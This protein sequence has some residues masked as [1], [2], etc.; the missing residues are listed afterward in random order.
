MC[1]DLSAIID[2]IHI[3]VSSNLCDIWQYL[4]QVQVFVDKC[5][6][7]I[8]IRINEFIFISPF[9]TITP[10]TPPISSILILLPTNPNYH[11]NTRWVYS[12]PYSICNSSGEF[13]LNTLDYISIVSI[14]KQLLEI[15]AFVCEF[16]LILIPLSLY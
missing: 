9:Y 12:T 13:L 16:W 6:G 14:H 2:V 5:E 15:F 1:L 8:K 10:F 11:L 3:E 4:M 7:E